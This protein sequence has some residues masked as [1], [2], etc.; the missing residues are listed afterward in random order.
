MSTRAAA[1]AC[2][3]RARLADE[4][5]HDLGNHRRDESYGDAAIASAR[6]VRLAP[7]RTIGV[8]RAV[9]MGLAPRVTAFVR[10]QKHRGIARTA[11][12][13]LLVRETRSELPGRPTLV[14][15]Q[16]ISLDRPLGGASSRVRLPMQ[17]CDEQPCG[18]PCLL[19]RVC[20][21][22]RGE[23]RVPRGCPIATPAPSATG[24]VR[25]DRR[26]AS[27]MVLAAERHVGP[28]PLVTRNVSCAGA[29]RRS[30]A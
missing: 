7:C 6:P 21:P 29:K 17:L 8:A 3:D 24:A 12:R 15:A 14:L 25:R 13:V 4:C 23:L 16:R 2:A 19:L 11:A 5:I 18:A 27:E 10:K 26:D 28:T 1:V 30:T 9:R 22:A 20:F